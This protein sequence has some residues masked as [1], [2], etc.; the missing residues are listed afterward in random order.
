MSVVHSF[1]FLLLILGLGSVYP[2]FHLISS[3]IGASKIYEFFTLSIFYFLIVNL[4]GLSVFD[5]LLVNLFGL[6]IFYFLL[7]LGRDKNGFV[8]VKENKGGKK[9]SPWIFC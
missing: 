5:F 4:F 2:Y 8:F 9:G 1:R 6:S 7:E 3:V